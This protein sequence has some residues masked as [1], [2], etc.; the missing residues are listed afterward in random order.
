MRLIIFRSLFLLLS[1]PLCSLHAVPAQAAEKDTSW[2]F[3]LLFENDL[4]ADTDR[5]YTNGIKMSWISPDL[6]RFR[7]S[8][9]LPDWAKRMA[10]KL[11]FSQEEGLQRNIVF[12]I[13][14]K[15]FTPLDTSNPDL[16]K[17]DRPYGGWLYGAAAFHNKDYRHL[18]TFELQAGVVGPLSFAE[19]TQNLIHDVR[20]I[21]EAR[22]WDNQLDNEPGLAFIYEHKDRVIP[23]SPRGLDF[24]AITHYGAAVG[25]VF[26]YANAGLEMRF[27]WNLPTDFGSSLIRPGGDNNAPTDSMDP[28]YRKTG[29]GF[30]LHGFAAV[31]GRLVLRD[32][33]LDGNTFSDSHDVDKK[34]LV[35][36]VLLGVSLVVDRYKLSYAQ[37]FRSREFDQQSSGHNFGSIS[38]SFTY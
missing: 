8:E 31:S 25:N 29:P 7:D 36:D 5:D 17:T 35:G 16:I 27:G 6:S 22:G 32:I 14:Q 30:S 33:F 10:R 2:T 4:F 26:T 38:L 20:G 9:E 23:A 37:V 11:P 28:R 13:G 1:L 15:M 18:D 34:L 24:D 3:T 12:S 21:D 19:E